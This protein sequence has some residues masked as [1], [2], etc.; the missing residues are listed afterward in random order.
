[1]PRSTARQNCAA[2][3]TGSRTAL[4][5]YAGSA[6]IVVPPSTDL[7]VLQPFLESLDPLIMPEPGANAA[8]VLPLA[9]GAV[10]LRAGL[11]DGKTE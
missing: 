7:A 9:I 10:R 8:A 3:R 1:M 4:I 2:A 5:A 6:H 11:P